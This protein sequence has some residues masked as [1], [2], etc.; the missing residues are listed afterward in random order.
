MSEE[1]SAEEIKKQNAQI[2]YYHETE[3]MGVAR[4]IVAEFARREVK[5]RAK[6]WLA[7]GI[8]ERTI[9]DRNELFMERVSGFVGELD[10]PRA[11]VEYLEAA[12]ADGVLPT[13]AEFVRAHTKRPE[14][15]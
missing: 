7:D 9:A 6:E 10:S 3:A 14:A 11:Y 15:P 2:R 5:A 12:R 8:E 4:A 1:M 13:P